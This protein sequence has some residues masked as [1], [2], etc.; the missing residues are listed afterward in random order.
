DGFASEMAIQVIR[1]AAMIPD[2]TNDTNVGDPSI[3]LDADKVS[4]DRTDQPYRILRDLISSRSISYYHYP[5]FED[6]ILRLRHD[7]T[8][9]N[10]KGSVDHPPRGSKDVSDA[11]CG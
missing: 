5:I 1:K 8:A 6:E 2:R 4:M 7:P 11:V 9:K 10:N 3:N